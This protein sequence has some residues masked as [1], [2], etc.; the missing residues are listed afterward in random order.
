MEKLGWK[1]LFWSGAIVT[2]AAIGCRQDE[3]RKAE[4]AERESLRALGTPVG[5]L[6]ELAK[7]GGGAVEGY[8]L[9]TGLP[10]TG[11]AYCPSQIRTYLKQYILTQLPTE[12]VNLDALIDSENTAVVWLEASLPATP[13]L[14]DH[15][16]VRVSLIPGS[17]ATSI[18]G[19]WLNKAQLVAKGTL[20]VD[21]QPLATVGGPV[22]MDPISTG[23][24]DVKSGSVLGGGRP[25][26]EY[27][28]LL[29]L[30]RSSYRVASE[31]RNR[32]SD[33]YGPNV[34]RA[35]SNRDIEVKIPPEY[36]WRKE[37]FLAMVPA[38]Y[39]GVTEELIKARVD[40]WV[41][42]LTTGEDKQNA[43]IALEAVGRESLG[44]LGEL[45][46]VS[47]VEVRLRAARCLLGLG[48]DRGFPVLRELAV[49]AK[50]PF[51]REAFDAVMVTA[52]RNDAVALAQRLLRDDDVT[53]VLAAYEHLR[54][55]DDPAVGREFVGRSF[56]L[57]RVVQTNRRAIFVSRSGAPRIVLFGAPL[58]C[59]NS[60][61]VES[62]DQSIVV[63]AR[64]EQEYI[65][66]TRKHP[67]RPGIMG[68][69]KAGFEVGAVVR[70]LGDEAKATSGGQLLGL[71]ASYEEIIAVL[72][73]L[74]AKGV[75]TA[76]FWPGPLPKIDLP[77]KK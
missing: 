12:R 56:Y 27:T 61:F 38:T 68:P 3:A 4:V 66:I 39:V 24:I 31:I 58:E 76:E 17:E 6:A 67:T 65:S 48:D 44:R 34:A 71:G 2:L 75:V 26:Y 13:S 8:G 72:K 49:D 77:V 28:A 32:L 63:N 57:E 60:I 50:S 54:R 41:Q 46:S 1:T 19:G 40:F 21:T 22:F 29:R 37:R 9:V 15:F 5:S 42:K 69:I 35:V 36:R 10:G 59:S 47:D 73:Q 55:L 74:T 43:E 70:A 30:R 11:S 62:P 23:E 52:K 14:E 53:M 20:G 18:R 64:E 45:L 16:D 7:P 51:R 33:R 25:L